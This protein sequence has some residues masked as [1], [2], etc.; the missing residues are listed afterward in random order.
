MVRGE[1]SGDKLRMLAFAGYR[2]ATELRVKGRMVRFAEPLTA[3]SDTWYRIKAMLAIYNSHE[4]AGVAVRCETDGDVFEA[5]SDDEGYFDFVIPI[6]K[7]LL[8]STR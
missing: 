3:G 8:P 5:L 4:V 6:A 7:P 2:N 1:P